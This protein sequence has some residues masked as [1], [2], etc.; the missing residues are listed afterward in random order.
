MTS[1]HLLRE[2][3]LSINSTK[4]GH[5]HQQT[6]EENMSKKTSNSDQKEVSSKRTAVT[7]DDMNSKRD[8]IPRICGNCGVT[9]EELKACSKCRARFYC[10]RGNLNS[11]I[12][13]LRKH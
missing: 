10:N 7:K 4:N 5:R 1:F 2:K 3:N 11:L 9:S 8:L 12:S 13:I 6:E